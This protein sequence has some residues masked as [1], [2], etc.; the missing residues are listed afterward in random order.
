[1][2]DNPLPPTPGPLALLEASLGMAV[3][4]LLAHWRL[5]AAAGGGVLLAVALMASGVIYGSALEEAALRHTLRTAPPRERNL[6]VRLFNPLDRDLYASDSRWVQETILRPLS[7]Y[8]RGTAQF[9]Q[10]ATFFFMGRPSLEGEDATRPRGAL[11]GISEMEK[12]IRLLEGRLPG[13][14]P[15]LEVLLDAQ[16]ARLLG[17]RPGDT[18]AIYPAVAN[19]PEEA[20]PVTVVGVF[21]PLDPAEEFWHNPADKFTQTGGTWTTVPLWIHP[22][23]LLREVAP[24]WPGLFTDFLWYLYLDTEGLR[25]AQVAP[26]KATLRGALGALYAQRANGSAETRLDRVLERYQDKVTVARIPLFLLVFLVVGIILYYL[27]LVG[28]LLARARA[29]EVAILRSR[30]A[31]RGQVLLLAFVEGGV[32]AFPAIALGPPLAMGMATVIGVLFPASGVRE[33]VPAAFSLRVLGLGV[34]G[35]LLCAVVLAA[36]LLAVSRWAVLEFRLALARPHPLP[37]LHRTYLDLLLLGLM[38]MLWWQMRTRGSF[39]VRPLGGEMTLDI[40]LLLGPVVGLVA[41]GLL[42]LRLF[43][44]LL[45]LLARAVEGRG[46]VWLAYGFQRAA[47]DPVPAGSLVL[48]LILAASLGVFGTSFRTT[49]ERSQREQALY[50]VGSDYRISY[51]GVERL[52]A[53]RGPAQ[54]LQ[55]VPG[56]ASASDVVRATAGVMAEG[57]GRSA[58]MLAVDPASIGRVA[59]DRAGLVGSSLHR[60]ARLLDT[61]PLEGG[62]PFPP[63]ATAVAVWAMP[64]RPLPWAR[65]VA[66]F[67]DAQGQW[68]DV[69]LGGLGYRG[70]RRL[71]A[72]LIPTRPG[73][74]PREEGGRPQPP[75][76]LHALVVL[77]LRDEA[78]PGSL[79]LDGVMAVGPEGE[80]V[81][82][83]FSD[84]GRWSVLEDPSQPGVQALSLSA[85]SPRQGKPSALFT[86]SGG[87]LSARGIRPGPPLQPLPALF[88]RTLLAATHLGIGE[89]VTATLLATA[90]PLRVVGGVEYFPTLYPQQEP[91]LVVPLRPLLDYIALHAP[92]LLDTTAEVWVKAEEGGLSLQAL[93]HALEREGIRPVA[94][95]SAEEAVRR[96][97][98]DPLLTAG[99][100]GLVLLAFGVT[101]LASASA[102]SLY[103]FLDT[104]AREG[105]YALL[106]ALGFTGR[107]LMGVIWFTFILV[108]A[109]G[110]GLG[111]W[112]GHRV[113]SG[114]LP[115][116]E[117]AETGG[118]ITPPM[119]LETPWRGL[120]AV[121]GALGAGAG[122]AAAVLARAVARLDLQGVLRRGE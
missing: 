73:R 34:L 46:P 107:Q 69:A 75:Y 17:L 81:L 9:A 99:W 15:G 16:G 10:T 114:L 55:G 121:Y 66:R 103:L 28:G 20:H 76:T 1:M 60:Q 31:S 56:V 95:L 51:H 48:L 109:V 29:G 3:R 64:G 85:A 102:I 36:S 83:D 52:L 74:F 26:L 43:P 11:Q 104:R 101:V 91:F 118:R 92:R 21:E 112:A 94:L 97:Q 49:Q 33:A 98:A 111:T 93:R 12:H 113:A 37:F 39:L 96:R 108:V 27:A 35:A 22:L 89:R 70:W 38:G 25:P 116:L 42:V 110:I 14:G 120:L 65:L 86:W 62:L 82:E 67:T 71:E 79:F 18:F 24:R 78:E 5:T 84:I 2:R 77:A 122:V 119:V 117:V 100:A 54:A 72:P 41:V 106:R 32:L 63:S 13:P 30:G 45:A 47:R 90:V 105:E 19:R 88:S 58:T 57:F 80:R 87:L 50:E 4:R 61:P 40:T 7:P 53:R 6:A 59:W 68:F 23:A 8:F 44:L 115:L